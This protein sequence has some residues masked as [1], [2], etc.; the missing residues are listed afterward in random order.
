[1]PSANDPQP[2][3]RL[4]IRPYPLCNHLRRQRAD[5]AKRTRQVHGDRLADFCIRQLKDRLFVQHSGIIDQRINVAAG[6][7]ELFDGGIDRRR[8]GQIHMDRFDI[9][10]GTAK[11]FGG[12]LAGLEVTR[13]EQHRIPKLGELAGNGKTDAAI[14]ACHEYCSFHGIP[15]ERTP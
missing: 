9:E 1:M 7:V 2:D 4:T 12:V 11:R 8:I 15:N 6:L 14:G 3:D 13:P 10:A 5:E